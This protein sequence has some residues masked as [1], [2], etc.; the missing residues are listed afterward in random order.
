MDFIEC[1]KPENG[2]P[3][4]ISSNWIQGQQACWQY[5]YAHLLDKPCRSLSMSSWLG[6]CL[7]WR[8]SC[9][10]WFVRNC[11]HVRA[12]LKWISHF[13][14]HSKKANRK[15]SESR[16]CEFIARNSTQTKW[17][18]ESRRPILIWNAIIPNGRGTVFITLKMNEHAKI[19]K[20]T[21]KNSSNLH[22]IIR[23][24][25][26]LSYVLFYFIWLI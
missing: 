8:S 17:K 19:N 3:L 25:W 15:D 20:Y 16:K 14:G 6:V 7:K 22:D 13:G 2:I 5:S 23:A 21:H 4:F 10:F 24:K 12:H 26:F 9:L 18:K 1:S 11:S